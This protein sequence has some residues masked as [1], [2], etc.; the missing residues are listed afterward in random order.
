MDTHIAALGWAAEGVNGQ[1]A[2][3]PA[4]ASAASGWKEF[5]SR[6]LAGAPL[7]LAARTPAARALSAQEVAAGFGSRAQ[8]FAAFSDGAG[9]NPAP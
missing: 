2:P 4:T 1:P 8:I 7:S 9:W 5:G 3:N 6:S